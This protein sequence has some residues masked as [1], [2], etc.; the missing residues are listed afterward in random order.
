MS[1]EASTVFG[2][3]WEYVIP[4]IT[5]A[6]GFFGSRLTMTKKEKKDFQGDRI[7]RSNELTKQI[8]ESFQAFT[9][10]MTDYV[11]KESDITLD[12]FSS[13]ARSGASY[14]ASI[15]ILCDTILAGQIDSNS[16]ENS[17][18]HSIKDVVDRTLPHFYQTLTLISQK[19]NIKYQGKLRRKDYESI[20][21]VYGKYCTK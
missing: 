21:V 12:D 4:F 14:F 11:N 18:R 5:F 17:H 2:I 9:K 15:K 7:N 10:S 20:Y 8:N 16:I 1:E 19:L 3:E 6:L 13:I